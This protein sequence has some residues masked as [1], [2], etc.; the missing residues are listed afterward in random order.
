M[1]F[2]VMAIFLS[3]FIF[4]A[5]SDDDAPV[6][7]GSYA[8][9]MAVQGSTG[10]FTYYTVPFEDVMTES[11]NAKG[12]GIAQD[13]Y[14]DFAKIDNA[15]YSIGGLGAVDVVGIKQNENK[16]L[17]EFGSVSFDAALGDIVKADNNTLVGVEITASVVK[18]HTIDIN[19][20]KVTDTK[21]HAAS[22]INDKPGSV[23][24]A[25]MAINGSNLFLAF[26]VSDPTTFATAYTNE[27][28]IA[29][30]SYPGLA[31]QKVIKDDRTGPIGGFNT[32]CGLTKTANGD[33]YALSHSNPANGYS[34]TTK[35]GGILRIKSGQ[36]TFDQDYFFD[37]ESVTG[38]KNISHLKYLDNNRAFAE[39]NMAVAADQARWSDS[40][41]KSAVVDFSAKTV[42]FLDGVPQHN[43]DGRRLAALYDDQ[44]VYLCIPETNTI[45]VYQMNVNDFTATKGATVEANFVAGFFR[46]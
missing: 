23:S 40:P 35:K 44:Y 24:Y 11:L 6:A 2:P 32:K 45:S 5:C 22:D 16:E 25:G 46:Y 28:V 30:Y 7:K 13:G 27:A 15:I 43:G 21:S 34:Q 20:V 18:F 26:Y 3:L 1:V 17:V 36:T 33:I 8:V 38:G 29:V 9:T 12:V 42:K 19:T 37:V 14:Y 10:T 31:L 4:T 39:V 41:L